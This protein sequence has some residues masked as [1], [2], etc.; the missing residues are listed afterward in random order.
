MR[1]VVTCECCGAKQAVARPIRQPE[2]LWI[3]C[4]VCEACLRIDV[5]A[6]DIAAAEARRL[7]SVG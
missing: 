5:T 7:A 4:H 1:A 6:T 3:I 2:R